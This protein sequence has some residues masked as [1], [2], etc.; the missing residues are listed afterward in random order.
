MTVGTQD[1]ARR[2]P[3]QRGGGQAHTHTHTHC[4]SSTRGQRREKPKA[5]PASFWH[6]EAHSVMANP[7]AVSRRLARIVLL[8][9]S[10]RRR[11]HGTRRRCD[12]YVPTSVSQ[13][14][15]ITSYHLNGRPLR[16][17]VSPC[18]A[19]QVG[20]R[21]RGIGRRSRAEGVL[22]FVLLDGA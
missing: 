3:M 19:P 10:S 4:C 1:R 12:L 22:V 21:R 8:I 15:V 7:Y 11:S 20:R 16:T 17:K 9:R 14:E 2:R 13:Y 18:L 6:G 5:G